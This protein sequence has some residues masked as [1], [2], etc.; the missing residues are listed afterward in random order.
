M[1]PLALLLLP[2]AALSVAACAEPGF[3]D[4]AGVAADSGPGRDAA[5]ADASPRPDAGVD[6]G[7]PPDA[8]V[9]PPEDAG[10]ADAGSTDAG[11]RVI[12]IVVAYAATVERPQ[13]ASL[14]LTASSTTR[15]EV[16]PRLAG[17]PEI[18]GKGEPIIAGVGRFAWT[19]ARGLVYGA[20]Q[21]RFGFYELYLAP[22][23]GSGPTERL[24][25]EGA[26]GEARDWSLSPLGDWISFDQVPPNGMF[27]SQRFAVPAVA[28][29]V[30]TPIS[31]GTAGVP[32]WS[33]TRAEIAF[34]DILM[35]PSDR[36]LWHVDLAVRP[37][38]RTRLHPG[39]NLGFGGTASWSPDGLRIAFAA[40]ETATRVFEPWQVELQGGVPGPAVRLTAAFGPNA[41]VVF[42][43]GL[44][45]D[46]TGRRLAFLADLETDA[47]EELWVLDPTG[48]LPAP[49]TRLSLPF[50]TGAEG[51]DRFV[52]SADGRRI[53]YA[54]DH[55]SPGRAELYLTD[56]DAANGVRIHPP[57]TGDASVGHERFVRGDTRVLY[58]RYEGGARRLYVVDVSGPSPGA[59]VDLG[60]IHPFF[61]FPRY[62]LSPSEDRVVFRDAEDP[63][64]LH[65][66]R[67]TGTPTVTAS[68]NAPRIDDF[69][70]TQLFDGCWGPGDQLLVVRSDGQLYLVEDLDAGTTVLVSGPIAA[71]GRVTDC[72]FP[73]P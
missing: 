17:G 45:Y 68:F 54:A 26:D 31:M 19:R 70:V 15:V 67:L 64:R 12:P 34:H 29:G 43:D 30:A 7:P 2:A 55:E 20:Q 56:A 66:A 47:L 42:G 40:D 53:L 1:R 13:L 5:L 11:P 25:L 71:G 69:G 14:F 72:R 65:L 18:G 48:P 38:V 8:G 35:G 36:D 4:D 16:T 58:T 28:G 32:F 10:A 51:V 63:P 37:P 6:A 44:Q 50:A 60:P 46:P 49:T 52:W 61:P 62:A 3:R 23:P 57:L 73:P 59:P 33:P 22:T 9:A 27:R 39:A 41:D 24:S 21:D